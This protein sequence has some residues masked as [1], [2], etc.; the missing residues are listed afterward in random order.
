MKITIAL[1]VFLAAATMA[2][3]QD[4]E[5]AVLACLKNYREAVKAGD[6]DKAVAL[7]ATFPK[8]PAAR[9]RQSTQEFIDQAKAGNLRIRL[10]SSSVNVL[11]NCAV[12]VI[13]DGEKPAPDDPAYLIQ[14]DGQWKVLPDL[15]SWEREYMEF[16]ADERRAFAQ[17]RETYK[18]VKKRLRANPAAR[19]EVE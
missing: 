18:Q 5:Q 1:I 10:Y 17:L 4:S 13:G 11:E 7:S 8:L 19:T 16:S 3:A 14:R 12:V 6:T 9:L 15:T 2:L